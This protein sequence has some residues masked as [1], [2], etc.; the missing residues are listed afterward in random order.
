MRNFLRGCSWS[1]LQGPP[2]LVVLISPRREC[3]QHGAAA[4]AQHRASASL[5]LCER[6]RFGAV[7]IRIDVAR[8]D[9]FAPLPQPCFILDSALEISTQTES[10]GLDVDVHDKGSGFAAFAS[11]LD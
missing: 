3:P 2:L 9:G 1:R 5:E 11:N 8:H 7:E 6:H 4:I 10:P